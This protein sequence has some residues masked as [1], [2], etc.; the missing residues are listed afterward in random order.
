MPV[1]I[2]LTDADMT[3]PAFWAAQDIGPDSTIDASGLSRS[4]QVTMTGNSITF[5]D[6]RTG[7]V[8]TYTDADL[9]GGSFSQFVERA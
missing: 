1:F 7:T 6:T 2:T 5:T 9:A 4:I 3:D 8:T